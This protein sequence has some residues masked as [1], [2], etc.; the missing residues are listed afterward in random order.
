MKIETFKTVEKR[1]NGVESK[2]SE[3]EKNFLE[4]QRLLL[5]LRDL[6]Q[7]NREYKSIIYQAS[8]DLKGSLNNI[9]SL[10][11][12]MIEAQDPEEVIL[13]SKPVLKSVS[14]FKTS[15]NELLSFKVKEN[16]TEKIGLVSIK[17]VIN[18]VIESINGQFVDA[19]TVLT[20]SLQVTHISFPKKKLRSIFFNLISN[21][22]KYK[23]PDRISTVHISTFREGNFVVFSVLD[24]GIGIV[25]PKMEMLFTKFSTL[26]EESYRGESL[27]IGLFLTKT[28]VDEMGGKIEAE[29]EWGK[30]SDFRVYL[31]GD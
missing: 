10:I 12:L 17:T 20:Q 28:L 5:E 2:N 24:N 9:V 11:N 18:E 8:H 13:L 30:G 16:G 7:T 22:I 1:T 21:A 15:M 14:K 31:K 4:N 25:S 29:S 27:G 3:L 19:G 23:S 26:H 6:Q